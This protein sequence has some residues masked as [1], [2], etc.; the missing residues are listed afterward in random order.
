ML[1]LDVK[2]FECNFEI[3]KI[4]YMFYVVFSNTKYNEVYHKIVAVLV[5]I[6]L[7]LFLTEI[8]NQKC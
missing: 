7:P 5:F 1:I 6:D 2:V 8:K 4:Y 3:A